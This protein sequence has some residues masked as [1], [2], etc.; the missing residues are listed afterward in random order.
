MSSTCFEPRGFIISKTVYTHS[1]CMVCFS[2]IYVH[3]LAGGRL[4]T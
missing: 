1:F 4:L 2:C 3:S